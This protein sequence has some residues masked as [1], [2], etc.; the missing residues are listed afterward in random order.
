MR[1]EFACET[2]AEDPYVNTAVFR[3]K[4]G[5]VVIDRCV[6]HYTY[7]PDDRRLEMDWYGCYVWDGK[8]EDYDMADQLADEILAL[9][10]LELEDDADE[11]LSENEE[12]IDEPYYCKPLVCVVDGRVI[13]VL[14]E[15]EV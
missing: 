10:R 7:D 6:T 13:P 11:V 15:E 2:N 5:D 4:R 8:T 1:I 12:Y 14:R 9:V 3:T